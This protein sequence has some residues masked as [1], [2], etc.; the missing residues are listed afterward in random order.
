MP[1]FKQTL[2][3]LHRYPALGYVCICPHDTLEL[4]PG[5][6]MAYSSARIFGLLHHPG[7][8]HLVR[9]R[10]FLGSSCVETAFLKSSP[11]KMVTTS[12]MAGYP[13]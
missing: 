6:R 12:K 9:R 1:L 5:I 8:G 13:T 10:L 2:H 11:G 4:T 7:V 3:F